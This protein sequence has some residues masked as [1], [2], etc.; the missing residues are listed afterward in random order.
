MVL[1]LA[2]QLAVPLRERN[3]LLVAAGFAPVFRERATDD[4]EFAT[5]R[6]T[7]E[8]IL[9]GHEPF[10]ALAIDRNWN[11]VYTNQAVGTLLTGVDESLLQPPVNVLRLS[12]HP[13]GLAARIA[14]LR[15]WRAHIFARLA[16]QIEVSA[17]QDLTALLAELKSFPVPPGA[18]PYQIAEP[19]HLDRIAVPFELITEGGLLSFISTTTIF[20]TALDITLSELAIESFFPANDRTAESLIQST[21]RT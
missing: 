4:P 14:N 12:L 10:P 6:R 1:R 2:E 5:A 13:D 21:D 11:M 7:V 19:Q 3:T 17:D 18:K 8:R 20:G 9:K 16:D 15:E